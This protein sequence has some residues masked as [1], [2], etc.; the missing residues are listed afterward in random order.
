MV[1]LNH[2]LESLAPSN[3]SKQLNHRLSEQPLAAPQVQVSVPSVRVQQRALPVGDCLVVA[4]DPSSNKVSNRP[5]QHLVRSVRKPNLSNSRQVARSV[6]PQVLSVPLQNRLA[7]LEVNIPFFSVCRLYEANN[8]LGGSGGGLGTFGQQ[9]QQPAQ[10][11]SIFG[12]GGQT[13][14]G[15]GAFGTYHIALVSSQL[16]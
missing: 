2:L 7:R 13:S 12:G 3:P 11:S 1:L 16:S 6:V 9:Q 8:E 5:N 14:T 10:Q 4:L 15:F